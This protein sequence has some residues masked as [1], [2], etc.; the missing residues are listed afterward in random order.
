MVFL[1][2]SYGT[3]PFVSESFFASGLIK[4]IHT[5]LGLAFALNFVV[6]VV[7]LLPVP[8]F[9]GYRMVELVIGKK[10][11][12]PFSIFLLVALLVNFLPALF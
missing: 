11:A 8:F 7:N 10:L 3:A 6:A 1:L 4:F 5:F 9:D 12:Q 2:F